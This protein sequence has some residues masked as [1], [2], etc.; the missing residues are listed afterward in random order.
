MKTCSAW[1]L[2]AALLAVAPSCSRDPKVRSRGLV[3]V[4]NKY[5][6]KDKLREASL[7]F[8]KAISVDRMNPEAYY[9]LGL[10][11]EKMGVPGAAVREFRRALDLQ[12]GHL[13][14]RSHLVDLYLRSY[15][16][17]WQDPFASPDQ[18]RQVRR[19]LEEQAE[20]FRKAAPKSFETLRLEGHLLLTD[21]KQKEAIAKLEA[22]N[23]IKPLEPDVTLALVQALALDGRFPDA[24]KIAG[25]LI[26][27]EKSYAPIYLFLYGQYMSRKRLEDAENILKT[28]I[29]N[30]PKKALPVIQ[31]AAHYFDQ[32]KR[33]EMAKTLD[34]LLSNPKDFPDA[35]LNVGDFY[36]RIREWDQA[37]QDYQEGMRADPKQ[38]SVYQKRLVQLLVD[39]DRKLDAV[40]MLGEVLRDNPRDFQAQALHA[41]LLLD[42]GGTREI[43]AALTELESL[44]ARSTENPN[45]VLQFDLGRAYWKRGDPVTAEDHLREAAKIKPDYLPPRILLAQL[46]L[47]KFDFEHASQTADE[48][49]RLDPGNLF[50]RLIR[51]RA[52][53][54]LGKFDEARADLQVAQKIDPN[55]GDV[56]Y[57]TG[58]LQAMERKF[59]EAE[60]TFRSLY[61]RSDYRGL[62]GLMEVYSAQNQ[63]DR[64]IQWLEAELAR[65]PASTDLRNHL[66][67][68]AVASGKYDLAI[69]SLK[70]MI[71][72]EPTREGL[73]VRLGEA[74][75]GAGDHG[76]AAAWFDKAKRLAPGDTDAHLKLASALG[77]SGR[78]SEAKTVYEDALRLQPDNPIVLNNLAYALAESG[79][80][81]DRALT[82]AQRAVQRAPQIP[83]FSDTLGWIYL[84]KNLNDSAV[85][86][87]RGLV[88]QVPDNYTSAIITGWHSCRRVTRPTRR[89][90]SRQRCGTS[91][92]K[93]TNPRSKS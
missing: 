83:H 40:R 57:Q 2:I 28:E 16:G 51:A 43:L 87:F 41:T 36:W 72:Q 73:Y 38:K 14:A 17:S 76:N 10:T 39:Q 27:K 77:M 70:V 44:V 80:D 46:E 79:G 63:Y 18:R 12:A 13:E 91:L 42:T 22:A 74:Y 86:V 8:R 75:E 55:S 37:S 68:M 88:T 45:P 32:K 23:Q 66:A 35:R 5:L 1:F 59:K 21:G 49:L 50:G 15:Q 3:E 26:G 53:A 29:A 25:V 4:G 56:I 6:S 19:L 58:L 71:E 60:A 54:G 20:A 48:I 52:Q 69:A 65:T 67:K 30:N 11:E 9:R 61:Q 31:L 62:A 47:L 89:R 90:N 64:A 82:L 24:E 92:P 84:K 33:A 85:S 34:H 93:K 78:T 81:L 7:M